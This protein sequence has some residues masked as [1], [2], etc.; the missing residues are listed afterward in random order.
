[1]WG[2]DRTVGQLRGVVW[3]VL[4]E[5]LREVCRQTAGVMASSFGVRDTIHAAVL[6]FWAFSVSVLPTSTTE[7]VDSP[8][9]QLTHL[10][11]ALSSHLEIP[12]R[13]IQ[14]PGSVLYSLKCLLY[15]LAPSV[16]S[17]KPL[18]TEG[19][20]RFTDPQYKRENSSAVELALSDDLYVLQVIPSNQLHC[21][22]YAYSLI[23]YHT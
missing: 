19:Y 7:P 3:S 12:P 10:W 13:Y 23:T 11:L 21:L 20:K 14:N 6:E 5:L 1:M 16:L 17:Q 18:L 4:G 22:T 9:R 8:E 2:A 15:I